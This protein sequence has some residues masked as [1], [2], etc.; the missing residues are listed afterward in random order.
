MKRRW[1][2]VI[3]AAV[4]PVP[5]PPPVGETG[6]EIT[7]SGA[8]DV[9]SERMRLWLEAPRSRHSLLELKAV[10]LGDRVAIRLVFKGDPQSEVTVRVSKAWAQQVHAELSKVL[11]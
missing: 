7:G 2:G 8:C 9:I 4:V 6:I 10:N 3:A 1:P 11:R 5:D